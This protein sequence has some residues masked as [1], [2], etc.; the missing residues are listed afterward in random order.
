V[1]RNPQRSRRRGRAFK[2]E[3]TAGLSNEAQPDRIFAFVLT[4][5]IPNSAFE[6]C[7]VSPSALAEV[8]RRVVGVTLTEFRAKL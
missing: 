8:F 5:R 1:R 2:C 6:L 4:F 7:N 3:A